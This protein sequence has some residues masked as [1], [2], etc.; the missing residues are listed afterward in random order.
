M[1]CLTR[2]IES[3]KPGLEDKSA[4]QD[5]VCWK[6]NGWRSCLSLSIDAR[7]GT[8]SDDPPGVAV[9]FSRGSD[10]FGGKDGYPARVSASWARREAMDGRTSA[11]LD[12]SRVSRRAGAGGGGS[13]A[14]MAWCH[15]WDDL[16]LSNRA[17]T[18][19]GF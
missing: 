5:K 6:E 15:A 17:F 12:S 4:R 1:P 11:A 18:P 8:T 2:R 19:S 10:E 16:S 3:T 14:A 9:S 7:D 13:E